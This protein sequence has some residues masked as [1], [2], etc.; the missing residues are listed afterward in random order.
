MVL[1]G[2]V[3]VPLISGKGK[4]RTGK[5]KVPSKSSIN[6]VLRIKNQGFVR[7]VRGNEVTGDA[8]FVVDLRIPN[9]ISKKQKELLKELQDTMN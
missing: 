6:D 2:E 9:K 7:E 1:G 8:Y 3:T 4:K 5:L